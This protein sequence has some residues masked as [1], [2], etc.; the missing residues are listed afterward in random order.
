MITKSYPQLIS[1]LAWN[2]GPYEKALRS[3]D[4]TG[5]LRE[6]VAALYETTG[7][8][9]D[10]L[11]EE[12]MSSTDRFAE[13]DSPIDF[14]MS[15]WNE[16]KEA[17][18]AIGKRAAKI[19][20]A[21]MAQ[22]RELLGV[23]LDG[24]VVEKES[25]KG[26]GIQ[27]KPTARGQLAQGAEGIDIDTEAATDVVWG[28]DEFLPPKI[29]KGQL[30]RYQRCL[31]LLE[32]QETILDGL[33][34]DYLEQFAGVEANQIATLQKAQNEYWQR[35]AE[36]MPGG[37]S[38]VTVDDVDELYRH[39]RRAID[40]I[41]VVDIA[42][43]DEISTVIYLGEVPDRLRQVRLMRER[44]ACMLGLSKS[45]GNEASIDIVKLV[46]RQR[47]P[48]EAMKKLGPIL[49]EYESTA[50]EAFRRRFSAAL[51]SRRRMERWGVEASSLKT[52]N[53]DTSTID[54]PALYEKSVGKSQRALHEADQVIEE[55]NNRAVESL[56]AA[57]NSDHSWKLRSE[58]DRRSYPNVFNDPVDVRAILE[59][60]QGLESLTAPQ[61]TQFEDLAAE[62][63]PDYA[64]LCEQMVE[65]SRQMKT[66]WSGSQDRSEWVAYQERR[67][68]LSKLRF[69]RDEL[70]SRAINR[71]AIVLTEEQEK[72][73]GGLPD[74]TQVKSSRW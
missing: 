44:E 35:A 71:L 42:F 39:R 52:E 4:V 73:I 36:L 69:D 7:V 59:K 50:A 65:T 58:Y 26:D 66:V 27:K 28:A 33:H 30:R 29:G 38:T 21:G 61:R 6:Q 40:A 56:A 31:Q 13:K 22:L 55:L 62:F 14:D 47:L 3:P 43:F 5:E 63:G 23:E 10:R 60:S 19:R 1:H 20:D 51:E 74:L 8:T 64:G 15:R 41:R 67:N 46:L 9:W 32:N 17:A 68:L 24:A 53:A 57:L 48:D 45:R 2:P 34:E 16:R 54:W 70:N 49:A 37:S 12:A 72:L 25:K 11:V 18:E